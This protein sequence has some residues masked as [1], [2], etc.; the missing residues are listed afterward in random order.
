MR[1]KVS[2]FVFSLWGTLCL[3]MGCQAD[4]IISGDPMDFEIAQGQYRYHLRGAIQRDKMGDASFYR[5]GT[6]VVV[7]F[8]SRTDSVRLELAYEETRENHEGE[9]RVKQI[10]EVGGF[11]SLFKNG[12]ENY[13]QQSGTIAISRS[14]PDSIVG[15]MDNVILATPSADTLKY[16]E[17]NA[18]FV[19]L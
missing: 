5:A 3:L 12:E 15:R 2:I 7:H 13:W 9:F 17:L 10:D 8:E 16:I 6:Y 18:A 1:K 14:T 4:V 11:I 19:A